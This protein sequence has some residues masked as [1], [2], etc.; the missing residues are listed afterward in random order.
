MLGNFAGFGDLAVHPDEPDKY[1]FIGFIP[2]ND[3]MDRGF[4]YSGMFI[5][6]D[7]LCDGTQWHVRTVPTHPSVDPY[8]PI[9]QAALSLVVEGGKVRVALKTLTP[10]F[11]RFEVRFDGTEWR[12]SDDM[13]VWNLREGR[14]R[15]EARTMNHFGVQGPVSSAV[16]DV[17]K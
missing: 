6:K 2:N 11:K 4:D 7:Q 12:A 10:N 5:V 13:F 9:G 3:L 14:N 16:L 1:G 8:F 17:G 15:I